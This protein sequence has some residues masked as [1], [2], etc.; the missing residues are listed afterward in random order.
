MNTIRL[1]PF[2][3]PELQTATLTNNKR[4]DEQKRMTL[5]GAFLN[6]ETTGYVDV[7]LEYESGDNK[8]RKRLTGY[9]A[10]TTSNP[11]FTLECALPQ[12]SQYI[13]KSSNFSG[14]LVT[15]LGTSEPIVSAAGGGETPAIATPA[16]NPT[17]LIGFDA[18]TAT[19]VGNWID[20]GAFKGKLNTLISQI[21]NHAGA[22]PGVITLEEAVDGSGTGAAA[23]PLVDSANSA[24]PPSAIPDSSGGIAYGSFLRTQRYVRATVTIADPGDFTGNVMAIEYPN[25]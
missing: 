9:K 2:L 18:Y 11:V 25:A 24:I 10:P 21:N 7:H 15:D 23:L 1:D 14:Y 13:L 6:G 4:N 5:I 17:L 8:T 20:L 3:Y 19:T 22:T 16:Y 12:A